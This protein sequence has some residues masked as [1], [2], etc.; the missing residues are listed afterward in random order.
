MDWDHRDPFDRLI[1]ATAQ[2]MH[3]SLISA[4][5]VFDGRVTRVW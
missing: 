3:I 2:L 4:D 1:L 5:T